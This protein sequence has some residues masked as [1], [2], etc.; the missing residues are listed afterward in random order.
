LNK[1]QKKIRLDDLSNL[2]ARNKRQHSAINGWNGG[3][4]LILNGSAGTGKT[5]LALSLALESVLD[6][7]TPYHDL[8]IV[9]SIVPTRDI[10]FLPGDEEEKK[11]AYTAPYRA[12]FNELFG[13]ATAWDNLKT[14]NQL[15][16]E[17]TSF[18]R[19]ITYNHAVIVVDEC[20]NLNYHE[21]CSVIT[22]VGK[23]CR[24][25]F[26]GDYRQ[27]DLKGKE[28]DGINTFLEVLGRPKIKK[29]FTTISF[30]SADI[31]RSG[32]VRDFIIAKNG[33]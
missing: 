20:Q 21:L 28:C 1:N 3:K 10:G 33:D 4:N 26:S 17:S 12:I 2:E 13:C 6:G 24:I 32:L 16:F 15:H 31:V 23:H 11:E 7:N 30:T 22:R 27:T 9:R 29:H 8:I 19:G 25:I 14:K 5:Y 18:I